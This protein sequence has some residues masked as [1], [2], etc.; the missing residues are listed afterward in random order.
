MS[1]LDEFQP[2]P[3]EPEIEIEGVA[4]YPPDASVKLHGPP[5]TGKT[6]QT[7]ERL[8][9]LAGNG[10]NV[11][12]I[13]FITYRRE[14]ADRFLEKLHDEGLIGYEAMRKPWEHS[15]R[16]IGTIHAVCNRLTDLETPREG[17]RSLTG[18]MHEF[19]SE[20]FGVPYYK[21]DE[22][23]QSTPGELMFSARSW[24]I[25]NEVPFSHWHR[26]PQYS[27]IAELWPYY[28]EMDEFDRQ[29]EAE[30]RER[31]I[32]DFEDMLTTVRD[33]G[34][35]PPRKILA[36]D[37]YHDFTPLQ[38]SIARQWMDAAEIVIV[39]GDPLQVVYS[40]KG[41]DPSMYLDLEYPEILL[42]RS[43]RVP[44]SVWEY[45]GRALR[46][47]HEPPEIEPREEEGEVIEMLSEPLDI[48]KDTEGRAMPG[49]LIDRYGEDT[50]FLVRTRKQQRDLGRA[51]KRAGI[52][53]SSQEGG[54][55]WNNA[56]KRLAIYNALATLSGCRTPEGEVDQR[57]LV[58]TDWGSG[59]KDPASIWMYGN[60]WSRFF[61]R[62]PAEF[63]QG[64]SKPKLLQYLNG[65][66]RQTGEEIGEYVTPEF[67]RMFTR[68]SDSVE[69]LLS[70]DD[71]G[72]I[73]R[74]LDRYD[75]EVQRGGYRTRVQ[76]IHAAK[77][78]EAE[79]VVLYDGIPSRV[80]T[81]IKNDPEEARNEARLWYVGCTRASER[82]IVMRGGWDWVR[83][84]LPAVDHEQL[85]I[86]EASRP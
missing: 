23:T 3:E 85:S 75:C 14:M 63:I 9:E 2:E 56:E 43:Y 61:D 72:L 62:V 59:R 57:S 73:A 66:T 41:A 17:N 53:F 5:G 64:K 10:Y 60:E 76:T 40:Y 20:S 19:C 54:Y 1:A 83:S 46:P 31:G 82:L 13:A 49:D 78:G 7:M 24:C 42:P 6:T 58:T 70:Y 21:S 39:N 68:G 48:D 44:R 22:E 79:N 77:G 80:A 25:E 29:W 67:W 27:E 51:L 33:G 11:G 52:I 15:T 74:A 38:D 32:A 69:F 55:G 37:E 65:Q 12:D 4:A 81:S 26:S 18:V 8:K 16:Y 45:A 71:A 36:V 50:M 28:P 30:K 35:S 34:I 47:E 86:A 84:Y